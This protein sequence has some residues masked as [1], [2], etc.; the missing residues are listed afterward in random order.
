MFLLAITWVYTLLK[1]DPCCFFF[2]V[3]LMKP[4][5]EFALLHSW[6]LE[7]CKKNKI[8]SKAYCIVYKNL[9]HHV[10][11][12]WIFQDNS[13]QKNPLDVANTAEKNSFLCKSYPGF[14]AYTQ[15][16]STSSVKDLDG[17]YRIGVEVHYSGEVTALQSIQYFDTYFIFSKY[18]HSLCCRYTENT[19][20]M[21]NSMR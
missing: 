17:S 20:A 18:I 1:W 14:Y 16:Y 4:F 5:M 21:L 2:Q 13:P 3:L 6:Y 8:M 11:I 10:L 19:V 15:T 7:R 9:F 12:F